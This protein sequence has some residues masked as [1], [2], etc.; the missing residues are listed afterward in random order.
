MSCTAPKIVV[1]GV[2][3]S[4]SDFENAQDLLKELGGD[5]G[6][7]TFDEQIS[8]IAG[9]NNSNR[10]SGVQLSNPPTQTE[11]PG[12]NTVQP[13]Q[14]DETVPPNNKGIP[15]TCVPWDGNY[16]FKVSPNFKVRDFTVNAFFPNQ[17]IDFGG[18]TAGQRCC[19]L[20]N[21]SKNVAEAMLTKFGKFR[22]NSAV[23]NQETAKPPSKSQHTMGQAMDIQFPGWT[24]DRYWE[25]AAWIRDNIPY[26]QFIYEYS[27]K[28]SVWYH[29]SYNAT[30]GVNP[31]V[32]V[33]TM[34]QNKYDHFL[35]RYA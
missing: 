31:A 1:G 9:G 3:I 23:R 5:E 19:N 29:L 6:D 14:S 2:T 26:D 21:L 13:K 28:G 16:D 30:G 25:N 10:T 34:W 17:L 24:L 11:L 4:T 12:S 32:K 7:P 18:L 8:N 22:I 20:Q 33:M 35:K 15:V 27:P